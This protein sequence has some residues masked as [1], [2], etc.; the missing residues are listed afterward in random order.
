MKNRARKR[1]GRRVGSCK[2]EGARAPIV[3]A[4]IETLR[5]ISIQSNLELRG[6]PAVER[7]PNPVRKRFHH[8]RLGP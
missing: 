7:I 3:E 1:G 2:V 5:M 8:G 6:S 4:P